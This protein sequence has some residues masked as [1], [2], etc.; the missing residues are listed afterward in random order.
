[1]VQD[2]EHGSVSAEL[3]RAAALVLPLIF[4]VTLGKLLTFSEPQLLPLYDKEVDSHAL[5]LLCAGP[6]A[7]PEETPGNMRQGSSH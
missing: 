3:S 6:S 1:M 5:I 2:E 7:G 4:C